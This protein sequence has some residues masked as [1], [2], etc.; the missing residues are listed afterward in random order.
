MPNLPFWGSNCNP[1]KASGIF[2][3][4]ENRLWIPVSSY[5]IEH[6]KENFLVDIGW[7]RVM[8][9]NG[10]YDKKAQIKA[11]GSFILSLEK[12]KLIIKGIEL[13]LS[14]KIRIFY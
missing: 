7:E 8:S 2:E 5:L 14:R 11:L 6:P 13:T 12:L 10:V 1:I 3:K 4:K 9:P